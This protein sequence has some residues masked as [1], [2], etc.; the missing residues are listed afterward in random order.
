MSISV[1]IITFNEERNIARCLKSAVGVADEIVVVDSLST[2]ATKSICLEFGVKFIEQPF[3]G[4][5]EQKNFAVSLAQYN[6]VL[7]LDADEALDERLRNAILGL[8]ENIKEYDSYSMNRLTFFCG[9]WIRHGAWYPDRKIRLFDKNKAQWGGINPHDKIVLHGNA[10]NK[11]LKGDILHYTY[12]S[13]DEMVAQN[14]K[15][16]TIQSKAMYEKGKRAIFLNLIINPFI[17]F[18]SGYIIKGGFLDGVNGFLI[19]RSIAY[20]TMIKYAKLMNYQRVLR[21]NNATID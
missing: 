4:Y 9:K 18:F 13:I 12:S 5:I 7:S 21:E 1:V 10:S 2:D 6:Y 20:H 16:T 17:A 19:A 8:K 11:H 15:F 3:L 14:N